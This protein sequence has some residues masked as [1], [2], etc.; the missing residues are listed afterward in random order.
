MTD[1]W[2]V[3]LRAPGNAEEITRAGRLGSPKDHFNRPRCQLKEVPGRG[4]KS[5]ACSRSR[6]RCRVPGDHELQDFELSLAE[7]MS[8]FFFFFF[9]FSRASPVVYGDSQA[10]G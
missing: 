7:S 5:E 9:V 10:R 6:E 2:K 1:T 8:L 4:V 3:L